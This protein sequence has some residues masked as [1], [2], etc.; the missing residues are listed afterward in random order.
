[1]DLPVLSFL[2]YDEL[3]KDLFYCWCNSN[4]IYKD[5]Y[6]KSLDINDLWS[7]ER[8]YNKNSFKNVFCI[9]RISFILTAIILYDSDLFLQN[10][11]YEIKI[12]CILKVVPKWLV[13]Q[14]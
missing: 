11:L 9:P 7:I 6:A 2:P 3:S 10:K 5:K 4:K 8:K 14:K 12:P 1:M 13:T